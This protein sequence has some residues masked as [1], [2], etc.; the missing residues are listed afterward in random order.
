[1]LKDHLKRI[2]KESGF[3]QASLAKTLGVTQQAVAKWE[4]GLS[5][6]K[7]RELY[8]LSELLCVSVD[9]LIGKDASP[10]PFSQLGMTQI[11]IVGTVRAGYNALAFEEDHGS[12][13]AAVRNPEEYFYLIV[14]GDSMEP[15]ISEG[16]LALARRQSTLEDGD[17]GVIVYG[18]GEGTLKRFFSKDASVVLQPFNGAYETLILSGDE[19][20]Y[21]HIAGKVVETKKRW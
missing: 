3:T 16:D 4:S 14:K 12:E 1:M 11:P 9:F 7:P 2:R 10:Q 6:P 13:L 20:S 17:L 21:L 15:Y 8:A 19:L 5:F 18:E